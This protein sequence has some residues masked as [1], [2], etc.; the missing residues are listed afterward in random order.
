MMA[1]QNLPQNIRYYF[2]I[3][4]KMAYIGSRHTTYKENQYKYSNNINSVPTEE[5]SSKLDYLARRPPQLLNRPL[6]GKQ[7]YDG[8][9]NMTYVYWR[10]GLE[11]GSDGLGAQRCVSSYIH[12]LVTSFPW[13]TKGYRQDLSRFQSRCH[14][15]AECVFVCVAIT[16]SRRGIILLVVS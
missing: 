1:A 13:T 15:N 14:R 2:Y 12:S 16:F 9:Q 7:E 10:K 6:L 4:Q 11:I 5:I 3:I 8:R